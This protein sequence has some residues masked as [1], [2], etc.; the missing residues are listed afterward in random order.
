[1]VL[2]MK[3]GY[4]ILFLAI[5]ATVV[6]SVDSSAQSS[7]LRYADR[8][9]SLGNYAEAAET[10]TEAYG[11][12]GR[13][14]TARMVAQTYSIMGDY[15]RS[16]E[17]WGV[18]VSHEGSDRDDF[19][20]YLRSAVQAGRMDSVGDILSGAGYTESDFPELDFAG[21]RSLLGQRANVKLV[22]VEGLNSDGSDMGVSFDGKGNVLFSS[23]RGPVG[24]TQRPAVRLDAKNS[25]YSS[26]RSNFNERQYYRL[27]S[28]GDDGSLS[29]VVTDLEDVVQLNGPSVLADRGI[30]FYTAFEGRTKVKGMREVEIQPGIYYGRLDAD[31]NI[32]E[33]VAFPYNSDLEYGVM[34]PFVDGEA[35]R[36]YFSSDMPGGYGKYDIYYV[37]FDGD[38][39][40]GDPV[41]LGPGVNTAESDSHP[42]RIGD[43]FYFSSRG[44]LGLGGMD[45]FTADYGGGNI[46]GVRNMG[47][48]YNSE[49]DDFAY[50]VSPEGRRYLTS[51]RPGGQGLDDIYT[52]EDLYKHLRASVVDCD[53][54]LIRDAFE[55]ELSELGKDERTATVREADGRVGAVL[56][57]VSDFVLKISRA[58]HFSVVD[59][60][61]STKGMEGDTLS[62]E[63]RLVAVPYRTPVYVD[64]VYYD[65]DR[66][67][68]RK[69]AAPAL[70]KVA[71]LL[72]RYGFMDLVVSS[73][74][75]S[76]ASD[77]Y[78]EAL[79]QRRADAVR[80]YLS[81]YGI[82]GERVRLEWSGESELVNDC[83]DGVP[84]PEREHQMNRRSE[85]VL[86][87]FPDP[88]KAYGL[89]EGVEDPCDLEQ[90]LRGIQE[91][92][93]GLPVVYFDFD[94]SEIRPVHRKELERVGIM[95]GRL[96]DLR[97]YIEGH[98]D[99]RGSDAYNMAL[100]E[101]RAKSVMEYLVKRGVEV[102]RM[103]HVWYGES[104]PVHD[105]STGDCS[106]AQHQENRRTVLRTGK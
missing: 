42:S 10:Y 65:L 100:S 77:A 84:C 16:F 32:T 80:D 78:N 3:T 46:S 9:Y 8:Q 6:L 30:V 82:P 4:K 91:E 48:P 36:L 41:N 38:M 14:E 75:D 27:Y 63:Y 71:E 90:M 47:V 95:M 1:M 58:G 40:F 45:V 66:S 98:T 73:H 85:L 59:S 15:A 101:R 31:G 61:L 23:D 52:I 102:S 67:E 13:Y 97:L 7:L 88:D 22:P 50:A 33:S 87:A 24:D 76:R 29:V 69:D 51:D 19:V 96:Q 68:I 21:M 106:G 17:W 79:S 83:G 18:T 94:R 43:R 99:Q 104:R 2:I 89:P 39:N 93:N 35:G 81:G 57:P 56:D 72:G 20:K 44:H 60:T 55:V 53:G 49:R 105:C 62:R 34:T 86:E 26:D 37:E 64:I 70:D 5:C 54:V 11:R 25:I 74:T 103:E 12:R 28:H 92:V